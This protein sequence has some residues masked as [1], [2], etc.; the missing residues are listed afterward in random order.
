MFLSTVCF[1]HSDL[2]LF[3]V[4]QLT[5]MCTTSSHKRKF[6]QLPQCRKK[7]AQQLEHNKIPNQKNIK[8]C[9]LSN[10]CRI[11]KPLLVKFINYSWQCDIWLSF[12][13][14]PK[15]VCDFI[16]NKNVISHHQTINNFFITW[17][18]WFSM[19]FALL[20]VCF[21]AHKLLSIHTSCTQHT[22]RGR[23]LAL[24]FLN[25]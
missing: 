3:L 19:V 10:P 14:T 16:L 5:I 1:V 9:S 6:V 8:S 18:F 24:R 17:T 15:N 21:N 23:N 20:L 13:S 7:S 22:D 11:L 4:C 12:I 2:I 25:N